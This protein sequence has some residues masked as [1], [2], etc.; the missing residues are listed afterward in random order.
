MESCIAFRTGRV[1]EL[2]VKLKTL[3][4]RERHLIYIYVRCQ[5]YVAIHRRGAGAEA[6]REFRGHV[7]GRSLARGVGV[8]GGDFSGHGVPP[9]AGL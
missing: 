7:D 4:V 1:S 6:L 8:D 2:P 5:G 9:V 3:K